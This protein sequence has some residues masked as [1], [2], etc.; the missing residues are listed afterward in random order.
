MMDFLLFNR[1]EG[2]GPFKE[3]LLQPAEVADLNIPPHRD[4]REVYLERLFQPGRFSKQDIRRAL[5]VSEL[6]S[7]Q[8]Y[9]RVKLC[10]TFV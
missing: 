7:L 10:I 4:P 5:S 1:D 9:L 8:S 2:P 3:V 6:F